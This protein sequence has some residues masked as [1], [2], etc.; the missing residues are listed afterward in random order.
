MRIGM[1]LQ[2]LAQADAQVLLELDT[3][4]AVNHQGVAGDEGGLV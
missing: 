3:Q 4:P 1:L 2:V